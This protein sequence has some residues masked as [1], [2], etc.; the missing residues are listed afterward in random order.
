MQQ[1][2]LDHVELLNVIEDAEKTITRLRAVVEDQLDARGVVVDPITGHKFRNLS[3]SDLIKLAKLIAMIR[4]R[5]V[6]DIEEGMGP[7]A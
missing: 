2:D 5:R 3:A 7:V 1:S 4:M 6:V